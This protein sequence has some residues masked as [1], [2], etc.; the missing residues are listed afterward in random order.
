M[1]KLKYLMK[2]PY[3]FPQ[4]YNKKIM[5]GFNVFMNYNKI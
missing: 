5:I 4:F 2:Q 3:I 1:L